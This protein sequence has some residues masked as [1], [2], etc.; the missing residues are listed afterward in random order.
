LLDSGILL[1]GDRAR[2]MEGGREVAHGIQRALEANPPKAHL[3]RLRGLL[4]KES[5]QVIG[6][7]VQ[8]GFLL[9]QLRALAAQNV[10]PEQGLDL[11]KVQL[12]FPTLRLERPNLVGR[13]GVRLAQSR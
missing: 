1:A 4:H 9:D 8:E 7:L 12:D 6:H 11:V 5:N 10:Q 2:R 13:V 3:V